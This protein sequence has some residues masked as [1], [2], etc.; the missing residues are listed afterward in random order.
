[1]KC[2]LKISPSFFAVAL[3]IAVICNAHEKT[4][5]TVKQSQRQ[6]GVT[7]F[8]CLD[9]EIKQPRPV[10]RIRLGDITKKA[11]KLPQP[12][13]PQEAKTAGVYGKVKAE[14]VV[15]I[16]TGE[17][18]WARVLSGHPLLEEAVKQVVCQ[19]RFAPAR[20]DGQTINASGILTYSFA[21]SRVRRSF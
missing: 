6:D 18:V 16:D 5:S 8:Q 1:M 21:G 3:S 13:Y 7:G 12:E 2:I 15:R 4:S 14:V 17:V 11:L 20:Y 19:A 9:E 10:V